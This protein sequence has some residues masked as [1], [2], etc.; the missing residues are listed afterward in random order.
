[1]S[2]KKTGLEHLNELKD[3][4][5]PSEISIQYGDE[6][7]V[8]Q[9]VIK[10]GQATMIRFDNGGEIAIA[11]NFKFIV[12]KKLP[13]GLEIVV[14]EEYDI[15]DITGPKDYAKLEPTPDAGEIVVGERLPGY[16]T[17]QE[18]PAGEKFSDQVI[19]SI[20]GDLIGSENQISRKSFLFETVDGNHRVVVDRLTGIVLNFQ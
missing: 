5:I 6:M 13:S 10:R 3:D 8:I 20:L 17:G 12:T 11:E 15:N 16:K 14:P 2:E 1:M 4:R 7:P 9:E 18:M 19:P